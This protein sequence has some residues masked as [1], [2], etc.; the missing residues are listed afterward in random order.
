MVR[1]GVGDIV[2]GHGED[3]KERDASLLSLQDPGAL[4]KRGQVAVEIGGIPLAARD[5]APA[6]RK[7]AQR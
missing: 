2:V 4:V 1:D 5:L 3:R 6:D 7:L